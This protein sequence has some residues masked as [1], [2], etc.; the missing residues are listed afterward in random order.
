MA[1]I[2]ADEA[3]VA[4]AIGQCDSK[5]IAIAAVNAPENI[6]ISGD[7]GVVRGDHGELREGRRS[8]S[9]T[10]GLACVPLSVA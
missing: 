4:R 5:R 3:T 8:V 7:R 10:D 1:A 6:V 9:A 2:F